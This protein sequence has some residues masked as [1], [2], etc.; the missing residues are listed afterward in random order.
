MASAMFTPNLEITNMETDVISD[1]SEHDVMREVVEDVL[2]EVVEE[3]LGEVVEEV[4]GEVVGVTRKRISWGGIRAL[5]DDGTCPPENRI[6]DFE[7][8]VMY[9]R[10][11]TTMEYVHTP[12]G[13]LKNKKRSRLETSEISVCEDTQVN[14]ITINTV[15]A[16][17][18][19]LRMEIE[20]LKKA[21][22][23]YTNLQ[24]ESDSAVGASDEV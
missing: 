23:N 17:N 5:F 22:K 11:K 15:V 7:E 14:G 2:G 3:V 1:E 13:I 8:R 10:H 9:D 19:N 12:R 6:D 18:T 20:Q 24:Q 21:L 4:L 16:I